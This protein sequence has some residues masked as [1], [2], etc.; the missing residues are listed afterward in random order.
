[1]CICV[2]LLRFCSKERKEASRAKKMKI[3]PNFGLIQEITGIW[4]KM[5]PTEVP[6]ATKKSGVESIMTKARSPFV[7]PPIALRSPVSITL[8]WEYV[9]FVWHIG[10]EI[11]VPRDTSRVKKPV[12]WYSRHRFHGFAHS[13]QRGLINRL[14]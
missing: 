6:E 14:C 8:L 5:R 2:F 1:M 11:D 9:S 10:C 4:E 12:A 3:K 7:V 13:D